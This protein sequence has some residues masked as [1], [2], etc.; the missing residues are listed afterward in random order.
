MVV[1]KSKHTAKSLTD[2]EDVLNPTPSKHAKFTP[3]S[4]SLIQSEPIAE[5][6]ISSISMTATAAHTFALGMS[7]MDQSPENVL[8]LLRRDKAKAIL[9]W[10]KKEEREKVERNHKVADLLVVAQILLVQR[11]LVLVLVLTCEDVNNSEC[12]AKIA[13]I[14]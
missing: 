12:N 9:E 6:L 13:S 10:H 1:D 5:P 8:I 7:T 14:S 11:L 4:S 2:D 3:L